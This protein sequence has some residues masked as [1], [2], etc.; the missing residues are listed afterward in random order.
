MGNSAGR[1]RALVSAYFDSRDQEVFFP[2][3]PTLPL[4]TRSRP[5]IGSSGAGPHMLLEIE[6]RFA[7]LA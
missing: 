4:S 2:N 7:S 6:H 3:D 1:G 5:A